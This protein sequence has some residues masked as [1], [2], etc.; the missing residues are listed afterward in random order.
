MLKNLT[1]LFNI[2]KQT[3]I[4]ET[5]LYRIKRDIHVLPQ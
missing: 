2:K 5:I 1:P 3:K 4:Y